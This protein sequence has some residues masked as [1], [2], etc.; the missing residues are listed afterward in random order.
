[1][2]LLHVV[3][4]YAS[5]SWMATD[6]LD[7][8]FPRIDRLTP[9]TRPRPLGV[10]RFSAIDDLEDWTIVRLGARNRLLTRRDGGTH[11]WLTV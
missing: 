1:D 4:P 10:G 11:E 9:S 6:E 5:P 7:A 3:Q 2:G 8:S